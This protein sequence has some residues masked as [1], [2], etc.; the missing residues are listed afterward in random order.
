MQFIGPMGRKRCYI[1][2]WVAANFVCERKLSICLFVNSG[3]VCKLRLTRIGFWNRLNLSKV[4]IKLILMRAMRTAL[5]PMQQLISSPKNRRAWF[6]QL[7]AIVVHNPA[8][9]KPASVM[10]LSYKGMW[11]FRLVANLGAFPPQ[12]PASWGWQIIQKK[13]TIEIYI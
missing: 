8:E 4:S 12:K 10:S 13:L 1:G 11:Y 9:L 2:R 5:G 7:D 3:W 6:D